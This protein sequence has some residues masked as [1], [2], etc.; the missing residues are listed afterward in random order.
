MDWCRWTRK[1]VLT[2]HLFIC[3]TLQ[4]TFGLNSEQKLAC[5][6]AWHS[7]RLAYSD[8]VLASALP[9]SEQLIDA[10]PLFELMEVVSMSDRDDVRS[11][12]QSTQLHGKAE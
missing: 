7:R 5:D 11:D 9:S 4:A 6:K 1:F 8:E 3:Y 12:E 2:S 10:I